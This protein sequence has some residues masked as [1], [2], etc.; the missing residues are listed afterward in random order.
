ML[1]I[2]NRFRFLKAAFTGV[3]IY[4][5]L[6]VSVGRDG[7]WAMKQL[8][9]QKR[10]LS[11][12]TANIQKINDEL[13]QEKLALEKDKDLI[14][15]YARKLGYVSEGEKIVL[16]SGLAAKETQIFDPGT[17]KKHTQ[18]NY[19][20]ESIC[21]STALII[22]VLAYMLLV[23]YDLSKGYLHF[24]KKRKSSAAAGV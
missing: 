11:T 1:F 22:T 19:I 12:H 3:L 21:K 7:I 6:N 16:I 4:V 14:A 20:S 23:L 8:Q 10:D 2:M 17:V 9:K 13:S 18:V 15:A 5:V 24:S